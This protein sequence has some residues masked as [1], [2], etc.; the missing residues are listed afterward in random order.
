LTG[1]GSS[2]G[3]SSSGANGGKMSVTVALGDSPTSDLFM[4]GTVT[5]EKFGEWKSRGLTVK[6]IVSGGAGKV[7]Q[8][9]A[10]GSADIGLTGAPGEASAIAKGLK[11]RIVAG[12]QLPYY[13]NVI[14]QHSSTASKFA[15]L[16]GKTFGVTS[17]GSAGYYATVKLAQSQGW[18]VNDDIKIVALGSLDSLSAALSSR[19]ID[20]FVFGAQTA[21]QLEAKGV[22]RDLGSLKDIIGPTV[23][24]GIYA[25][26]KLI[27]ENPNA[28]RAYLNGY[29]AAVRR[30]QADKSE[31]E[32]Q[33]KAW[34][35]DES[36]AKRLSALDL[37]TLVSD[38]VIPEEN[39]K[40]LAAA[41]PVLNPTIKKAPPIDSIVDQR[42][43]PANK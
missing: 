37:P 9:L 2:G 1:C 20:A 18:K 34:G 16:K 14:V 19:S 40:G 24:E 8:L 29:F 7:N 25:T 42:F 15:D 28:L 23:F 30:L 17:I 27:E 3:D 35:F 5:A 13:Q 26:Q 38:G 36:I 31:F 12:V 41:V 10:A 11:A 21:W 43:L 22:G 32:G 6:N 33:L 39:L 4:A